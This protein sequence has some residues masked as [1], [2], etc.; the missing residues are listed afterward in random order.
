[1]CFLPVF[2]S[3]SCL[4][5][6]GANIVSGKTVRAGR[7]WAGVGAL[8]LVMAM[9][10]AA[11]PVWAVTF[12]WR[13]VGGQ[14]FTT[15]VKS[16][17]GCGSCWAFAA[18]G[19]LE[20]YWDIAY[21]NPNLNLNLSEQHLVCDGSCGNC[22]GG[23]EF[24]ALDFFI[25]HG[26]TDEATLPYT[27]SNSSP[28]WPLTGTW[29]VYGSTA[30]QKFLDNTTANL[31]S[32]LQSNGPLVAAINASDDFFVPVWGPLEAAVSAAGGEFDIEVP[33]GV[34]MEEQVGG[35]NHA[36][37]VVGFVDDDTMAEGGYWI[38]KNSW[39]AGWGPT[40][41]GYGYIKYGVIEE[42][43]RIHAVAGDTWQETMGG[44][45]IPEPCTLSVLVIGLA[46][47]ALRRRRERA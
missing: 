38:V 43:D 2:L 1:M 10:V 22:S 45:V 28:N 40:G 19:A 21:N 36:I 44:D 17:G 5:E 20:A 15:P 29:T 39:G 33:A 47:A 41:D 8:V 35:I 25:S 42:H 4:D 30:D 31:K 11:Q 37:C 9:L 13:N 6:E 3:A 18:V 46:A 26:I 7:S 24:S 14:D 32:V 23:W 12:D 27:A 34:L 16:Q